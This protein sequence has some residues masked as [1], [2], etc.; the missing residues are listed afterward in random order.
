[1]LPDHHRNV[2]HRVLA[3]P[4]GGAARWGTRSPQKTE[5]AVAPLPEFSVYPMAIEGELGPE[6]SLVT[7]IKWILAIPHFVVLAVLMVVAAHG[8]CLLRHPLHR[9]G[10]RY[11]SIFDFN[12]GVM[13]W[14]WRVGFHAFNPAGTD[15]Y[16]PFAL[17]DMDYRAR[18]MSPTAH[19]DSVP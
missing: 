2:R 4:G 17:R 11:F 1:M 5:Q 16:P 19:E 9:Q 18:L 13:R 10:T 15:K 8:R 12:V 3:P 7:L 14:T 6:L